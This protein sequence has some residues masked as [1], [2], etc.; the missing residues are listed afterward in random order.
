MT[1]WILDTGAIDHVICHKT[2]FIAFYKIKPIK[3]RLSNKNFVIVE[4]AGTIKF[5]KFLSF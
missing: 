4:Y 1:H 2:Q 3:I 5:L